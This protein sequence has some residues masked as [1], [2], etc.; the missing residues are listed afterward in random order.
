MKTCFLN[1]YDNYRQPVDQLRSFQGSIGRIK[2]EMQNKNYN[3]AAVDVY[4][5]GTV[6]LKL[7]ALPFFAVSAYIYIM[8]K[9]SYN[10]CFSYKRLLLAGITFSLGHDLSKMGQNLQEARRCVVIG[11]R[12]PENQ[13]ED[14]TSPRLS[15]FL[16]KIVSKVIALNVNDHDMTRRLGALEESCLN[17][18]IHADADKALKGTIAKWLVASY[19]SV[20]KLIF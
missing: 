5:V 15:G 3:V 1:I 13:E 20:N 12:N 6:A 2:A 17:D 4:R 19:V 18:R 14:G 10:R 11:S 16:S 8:G 7:I 9:V